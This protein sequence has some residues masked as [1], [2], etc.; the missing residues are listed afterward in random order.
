[1]KVALETIS[2]DRAR[3]LLGRMNRNRPLSET[4][5][6]RYVVDMKAGRWASDNGQTIVMSD[7]GNLLD[8]QHR[9]HA[10]IQSGLSF[11][12][13]VA[14]GVAEQHFDTMDNGKN[15]AAS[16]ILALRG[17]KNTVTM[18][19][20]ARLSYAYA[21]GASVS[22]GPGRLAVTSFVE[23]HPYIHE[24]SAQVMNRRAGGQRGGL[25]F[26][27]S[28]LGAVLFL[29]NHERQHDAEVEEFL[30]G[31]TTGIG[32]Q[33]GDPRLALREWE[34]IERVR[35]RGAI[36]T[37]PGFA[38]TAR[39]WNAWVLNRDLVRIRG[40]NNPT[41]YTLPVEGFDPSKFTDVQTIVRKRDRDKKVA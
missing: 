3:Q 28:P 39:A 21:A 6:T 38:A 4:T 1:M 27:A 31:V 36:L 12:F 19:A 18:S 33:S 15:R 29:G 20:I 9:L 5:V 13:L 16:D 37:E 10:V 32:L 30:E 34:S 40:I 7:Q 41:K 25:R 11:P 22:A 2:P 26:P 14:Y 8:G 17:Y 23:A 24:V 35:G